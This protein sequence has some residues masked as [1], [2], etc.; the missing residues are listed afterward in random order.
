MPTYFVVFAVFGLIVG[1]FLN[2]CIYRIPRGESVVTP[3]SHCPRC[4]K[5]VRP[6]DNVPV[7]AWVWLGGRCR[8][9]RE[10]ISLEYPLVETLNAAAWFACAWKWGISPPAFVNALFVSA[11]IVLVFIDYHHQLLPNVITLPGSVAGVLLSSLQDPEYYGDPISGRLAG[12]FASV[13]PD[14]LLRWIEPLAGSLLGALLVAGA[15]RAIAFGYERLR[16]Q[17][18]LGMGDVKMM[19][20]VG[21]FLGWRLALLTIF[22]G[23]FTGLLAGL[24]LIARRGGS[25][26]TALPFGV[27]LGLGAVTCLFLGLPLLGWYLGM[28]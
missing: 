5:A 28:V 24:F 25:L 17:E 27:F 6:W 2:V 12:I 9:C 8:D 23:A 7:L 20:M 19:L 4:G 22:L 13:S 15:L 11:L 18:G 16:K 14:F 21:A 10:P 3:G 26:Q 1:S